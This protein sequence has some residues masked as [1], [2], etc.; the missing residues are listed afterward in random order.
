[1]R[2]RPVLVTATATATAALL[3]AGLFAGQQ[4]ASAVSGTL[5]VKE[6][7]TGTATQ[8]FGA[9]GLSLG[10]HLAFQTVIK[11]PD[12]AKMGI[13]AGD[14]VL[15]AGKTEATSK[16]HCTQTLE[17]A[18]GQIFTGGVSDSA[19][20]TNTFAILGGTGKYRGASGVFDA[21]TTSAGSFD[22]YL[23]F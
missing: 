7:F 16:Y 15:Y 13:G 12:G 6:T 3:A 11:D 5:H 9:K 19:K 20:K 22:E 4:S 23:R 10:D 1:M 2:T 18:D 8:D 17:L 21:T 14:C